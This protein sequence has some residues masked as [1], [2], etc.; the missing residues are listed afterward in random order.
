MNEWDR[1]ERLIEG[2]HMAIHAMDT[3]GPDS[4]TITVALAERDLVLV[5]MALP[6]LQIAFPCLGEASH[7]LQVRLMELV[8]AQRPDWTVSG[9]EAS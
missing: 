9:G 5:G 2:A 7:D 4:E 3:P 1:I 8:S 6:V